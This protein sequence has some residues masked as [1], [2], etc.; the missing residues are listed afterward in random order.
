MKVRF[1][2]VILILSAFPVKQSFSQ[3]REDNICYINNSRIYFQLDKRWP[4]KK[5][6]EISALFS[7]DSA[8]I[9]LA[10]KGEPSFVYDSTE[11]QVNHINSDIIEL[12]KAVSGSNSTYNP[13]DIF[14]IDDRIF[15]PPAGLKQIFS[16][17]KRYGIN[18][19][20]K[21]PTV[22]YADGIAR[23]TLKGYQKTRQVYLS[24]TFNNWS[25]M[26]NPVRKTDTGWE[27]SIKLEPGRYLYKYIADG[28]W[29]Q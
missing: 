25:T 14:L 11:W 23:F 19:F 16:T 10:F 27:I 12:S 5:K 4:D 2:I 17:P 20:A 28:K 1:I 22:E 6:K 26:Q 29:N 15:M 18:S 24:G 7:L 8:L 21:E 9:E 13:N 3:N